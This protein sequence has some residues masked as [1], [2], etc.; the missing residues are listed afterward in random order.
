[1]GF[2]NVRDGETTHIRSWTPVEGDVDVNVTDITGFEMRGDALYWTARTD[3]GGVFKYDISKESIERLD[4]LNRS[5]LRV[6]S[7]SSNGFDVSG[8][9]KYFLHEVETFD[10]GTPIPFTYRPS[11]YYVSEPGLGIVP[12]ASTFVYTMFP[13]DDDGTGAVFVGDY[14]LTADVGDGIYVRDLTGSY[15]LTNLGPLHLN[16]FPA[17]K[18][19]SVDL[20]PSNH[21]RY[22]LAH[23]STGEIY[24]LDLSNMTSK[25]VFTV[26]Q[27]ADR[28]KYSY[29]QTNVVWIKDDVVWKYDAI[30]DVKCKVGIADDFPSIFLTAGSNSN[31]A[32]SPSHA[33]YVDRTVSY[34][35]LKWTH[36]TCKADQ[37]DPAP[38]TPAPVTPAPVTPTPAPVTPTPAPTPTPDPAIVEREL[39]LPGDTIPDYA[40]IKTS[41]SSTVYYVG[42]D[43]KRYFFPSYGV[44]LSWYS[45][46]QPIMT[47]SK[48]Q[49]AGLKLGGNVTYRPGVK[50]VKITTDPKV[51]AVTRNGGLRWITSETIAK[52]L[53]GNSWTTN[54]VDV[55]DSYFANYSIGS[56]VYSQSDFPVTA[57]MNA[58]PYINVDKGL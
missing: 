57:I 8:T 45:A 39:F 4:I 36:Y 24:R 46:D 12:E 6:T 20:E 43:R 3:T 15:G 32:Y 38:V 13:G 33:Y 49:M 23:T 1:M 54:V 28:Y 29:D 35:Y 16:P 31:R 11:V 44:Y 52:Q 53:Y 21:F 55:D 30:E 5:R 40:L 26:N 34:T 10:D 2:Q 41:D 56:P 14:L 58:S 50:L 22:G 42:P 25:K 17:L 27:D 47:V 19:M 37:S 9:G 51:Y 7:N 48:F 18:G